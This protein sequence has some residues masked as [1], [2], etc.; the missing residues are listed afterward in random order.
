MSKE[1]FDFSAYDQRLV[2]A[3]LNAAVQINEPES[4]RDGGFTD[5]ET[6]MLRTAH[7]LLSRMKLRPLSPFEAES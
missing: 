1:R 7:G 5:P 6:E 2:A 3:A 4:K